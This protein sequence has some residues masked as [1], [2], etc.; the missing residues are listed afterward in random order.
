MKKFVLLIMLIAALEVSAQGRFGITAGIGFPEAINLGVRYQ[1][2]QM[3]V[4]VGFG[5]DPLYN[6]SYTSISGDVYYHFGRESEISYLKKWYGRVVVMHLR[7]ESAS[8]IDKYVFLTTRI[9]KA[10]SLSER[11]VIDLDI[12]VGFQLHSSFIEKPYTPPPSN[13]WDFSLDVLDEIW[14]GIGVTFLYRL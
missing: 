3:Q 6:V 4:G 5:I 13:G 14:P 8:Y 12:G 9:G 1:I 11:F 7:D 2:E 10:C